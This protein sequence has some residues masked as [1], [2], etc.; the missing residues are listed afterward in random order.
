MSRLASTEKGRAHPADP[1]ISGTT[2]ATPSGRHASAAAVAG[3]AAGGLALGIS[4]LMAGI[5]RR[6]PSLVGA[7]GDLVIDWLP[8]SVVHFGIE[9]FGTSDKAVLV[10]AILVVS[11]LAAAGLG[12]L[13]IRA[14]HRG[15]VGFAA[16]GVVGA[17]A[18]FRD[19]EAGLAPVLGSTTLAVTVG[20][21]ALGLLLRLLPQK[22]PASG[23]PVGT[24]LTTAGDA[25]M[26]QPIGVPDRRAFLVAAGTAAGAAVAF[27]GLG[28]RL[29][30][31][32]AAASRGRYELPGVAD[33]VSAPPAASI[34]VPGVTPVVVPSSRFYQIDT[35]LLGP[36]AVDADRWR[37]RIGGLVER[38]YELD[39]SELLALPMVEEYVTLCCVSNEV[40]GELVG[41]AAWR[42]V[43][44]AELLQ[45]AGVNREGTQVVGR[46]VDGFTVGF[47]TEAVFDGRTALVAVGMNGEILPRAHG[48][49]ARLVVAGL[50][51]YVSATKWLTE[52]ELTRFDEFDA[53]WVPRGWSKIAP[54]KT[55]S[56]IDVPRTGADIGTGEVAVAGVAWAPDIGIAAV[57]VSVDDG[58]WER[59]ELGASA[60]E[61]TW[62]QWV[63]RWT[64]A[65]GEHTLR[66][67]ATDDTGAVQTA[68][69]QDPRP[70]G[71]TGY[72]TVRV[73]VRP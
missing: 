1:E 27:S 17:L 68:Q 48:F 10:G 26:A 64:A 4:E 46:S 33:P 23:S 49:P 61:N 47:P 54:V 39:F 42:G 45:R 40:G 37:L 36:P 44:L 69:R 53:Y 34:D 21:G 38:P 57:E 7:V 60:N 28:R 31:G 51:G 55:Q 65:P 59:A 71:A 67:R 22:P 29:S 52:I 20:I 62:V 25:G 70:D 32:R 5:L 41:N 11:G 3:V 6:T 12:R 8:A 18:A 63:H 14:F 9:T 43:R 58:P 2:A 73:V 50:Y 19:P 30:R 66:C 24:I 56:R 15:A 35:R 13:G 16:F 72:H